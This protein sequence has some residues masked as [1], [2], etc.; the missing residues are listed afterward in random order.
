[1]ALALAERIRLSMRQPFKLAD[2]WCNLISASIGI[3]IY[4]DHGQDS[5]TLSKSADDAMFEAKAK[6]RN[7]VQ[8]FQANT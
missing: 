1:V 6:G 2:N 5:A 7:R 3:A 4:P 8:L